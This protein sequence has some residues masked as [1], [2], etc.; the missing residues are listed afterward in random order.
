MTIDHEGTH[1]SRGLGFPQCDAEID[2]DRNHLSLWI[3]IDAGCIC[4]GQ[5]TKAGVNAVWSMETNHAKSV[6]CAEPYKRTGAGTRTFPL[7]KTYPRRIT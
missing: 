3:E 4:C 7:R 6:W 5:F 1:S 2:G